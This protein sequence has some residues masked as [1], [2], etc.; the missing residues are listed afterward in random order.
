[1]NVKPQVV[2]AGTSRRERYRTVWRELEGK[3]KKLCGNIRYQV[4]ASRCGRSHCGSTT[5]VTSEE[6]VRL[7]REYGSE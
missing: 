1:M 2:P 7:F 6:T 4:T 3:W 5:M